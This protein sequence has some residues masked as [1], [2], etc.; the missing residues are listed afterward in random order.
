MVQAAPSRAEG[1]LNDGYT[2]DDASDADRG[3]QLHKRL[4]LPPDAFESELRVVNGKLRGAGTSPVNLNE[5]VGCRLYTG[6]M[7]T[8][9][10]RVLRTLGFA[11]KPGAKPARVENRYTTTLHVINSAVIKLAKVTR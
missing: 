8:K 7:Y 10:N 3:E 11:S 9:Y 4:R 6:P 5:F 2:S 1:E